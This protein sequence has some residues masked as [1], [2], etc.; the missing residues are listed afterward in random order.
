MTALEWKPLVTEYWADPDKVCNV[1]RGRRQFK[2]THQQGREVYYYECWACGGSGL[3]SLK[4][5]RSE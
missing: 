2:E 3:R 5:Q 1:C 4:V